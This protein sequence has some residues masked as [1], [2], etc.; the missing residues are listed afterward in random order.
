M[1]DTPIL[2]LGHRRGG[3]WEVVRTAF[4]IALGLLLALY[5]GFFVVKCVQDIRCP[6]TLDYEE[7]FVLSQAQRLSEGQ[8]LYNDYSH[9]PFVYTNYPPV[10]IAL[11]SIGVKLFG[12][13]F[14]FGRLL[15]FLA[16]LG[17]GVLMFALARRCKAG[18][19]PALAAPAF[20]LSLNWITMWA[21]LMRV[22]TLAL[23]LGIGGLYCVLRRGKW[24]IPAVVLMVAATYTKQSAIAALAAGCVYLWWIGER[25][26]AAWLAGSW[27]GAV[28][29][30]FLVFQTATHG[31]FYRHV[32]T[33]NIHPWYV[34]RIWL[35]AGSTL[36]LCP[37]IIVMALASGAA[38]LAGRAPETD[39]FHGRRLLALY[40]GFAA[41]A[42][43][44]V[45]KGGTHVN[46]MI[47]MLVAVCL[48]AG[49]GY[50]RLVRGMDRS[51]AARAWWILAVVALSW[52]AIRIWL[53]PSSP[54]WVGPREAAVQGAQAAAQM[55]ESTKGDIIGEPAGALVL[56]GRPVL[57]DTATAS[58]LAL[59]GRWDPA[60]VLR[61]IRRQRFGLIFMTCEARDAPPEHGLYGSK[62][63]APMMQAILEN[64]RDAGRA[65]TICF[66]V[67]RG[68][69]AYLTD[70]RQLT[71]SPR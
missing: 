8:V 2:P 44:T 33:A 67:P 53:P 28:L 37:V 48:V 3:T 1:C 56:A 43:L 12:V 5:V 11:A 65:G 26:N 45:G 70:E 39:E 71:P 68:S 7:G 15:A 64:Y 55:I 23:F 60:P 47:E 29:A 50:D 41:V 52:Q 14:V 58:H 54:I 63:S 49:L 66:L 30:I 22:D 10:F 24:L 38:L 35:F 51:R 27:A 19:A 40:L 31:W 69:A 20:F 57:L 16:T 6:G 46:H 18:L 9:Y 34:D 61:D 17:V 32:V 62:W 42:T 36:E 25:R 59:S 21:G 13:N 4:H